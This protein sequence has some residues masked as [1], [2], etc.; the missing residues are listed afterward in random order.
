MFALSRESLVIPNPTGVA[1]GGIYYA[2]YLFRV[3]NSDKT[4]VP[5]GPLR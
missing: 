2:T 1:Y 3:T 5:F 4:V